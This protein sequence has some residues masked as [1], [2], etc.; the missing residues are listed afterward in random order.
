MQTFRNS[1][2][3][4]ALG[5]SLG[6]V[7]WISPLAALA[8][9]DACYVAKDA[10]GVFAGKRLLPVVLADAD[11]AAGQPQLTT[12]QFSGVKR[13]YAKANQR[14]AGFQG[15]MELG[16]RTDGTGRVNRVSVLQMEHNDNAFSAC[17]AQLACTWQVANVPTSLPADAQAHLSF[18]LGMKITAYRPD[19]LEPR[20]VKD[21]Q[22]Y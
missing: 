18:A 22:G 12:A 3:G 1:Y 16:L 5:L 10:D 15:G 9:A 7:L 4:L 20:K 6:G 17:V 14:M 11:A 2:I 13:C 8:Q 21:S 19:F